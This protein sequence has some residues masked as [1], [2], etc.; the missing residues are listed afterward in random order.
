MLWF[1][2]IIAHNIFHC[3]PSTLRDLGTENNFYLPPLN[4]IE[5]LEGGRHHTTQN[6][7]LNLAWQMWFFFHVSAGRSIEATLSVY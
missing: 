5:E 4:K 6:C 3:V 1:E 7:A 2:T